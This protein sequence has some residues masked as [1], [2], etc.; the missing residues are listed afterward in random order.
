MLTADKHTLSYCSTNLLSDTAALT[1]FSESHQLTLADRF[2]T[3]MSWH[4]LHKAW[5][6]MIDCPLSL[7]ANQSLNW[8][9]FGYRSLSLSMKGLAG[10]WPSPSRWMAAF[11]ARPC[12]GRA[13]VSP[14]TDGFGLLTRFQE[15]VRDL[16]WQYWWLPG[17]LLPTE[18]AVESTAIIQA[19]WP[20]IV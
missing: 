13:F 9:Q 15:I 20:L 8:A 11:W 14:L 19:H 16:I 4:C 5:S 6:R 10:A 18:T 1:P 17:S 2:H 12:C 7:L 3:D